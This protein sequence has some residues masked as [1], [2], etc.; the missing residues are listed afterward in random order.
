MFRPPNKIEINSNRNNVNRESNSVVC[1]SIKSPFGQFSFLSINRFS[2][3]LINCNQHFHFYIFHIN[4][5]KHNT[6]DR[7]KG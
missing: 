6:L 1:S 4:K 2:V 7:Y 5:R 3:E